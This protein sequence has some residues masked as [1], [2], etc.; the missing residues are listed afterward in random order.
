MCV[1]VQ[2]ISLHVHTNVRHTSNKTKTA[3][4]ISTKAVNIGPVSSLDQ[5]QEGEEKEGGR[6]GGGEGGREGE[7]EGRRDKGEREEGRE[8]GRGREGGREGGWASH[9]GSTITHMYAQK[10]KKQKGQLPSRKQ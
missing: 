10:K 2:Y 6:D 5:V 7:R 9:C 8:R 4:L 3:A 1:D